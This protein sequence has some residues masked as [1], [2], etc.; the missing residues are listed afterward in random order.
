M[1]LLF[2]AFALH[3]PSSI[4]LGPCIASAI[5][6]RALFALFLPRDKAQEPN[7]PQLPPEA[8]GARA[9]P[10]PCI[11]PAASHS[12]RRCCA[13]PIRYSDLYKSAA[14]T[15][16]A[17]PIQPS[18]LPR[19]PCYLRPRHPLLSHEPTVTVTAARLPIAAARAWAA[20]QCCSRGL[21]SF[22]CRCV[23]SWP[24]PGRSLS[25]P[26]PILFR[27][28]C[29]LG[30][31]PARRSSFLLLSHL[32]PACPC[33]GAQ[34]QS[35]HGGAVGSFLTSV[36][37][38]AA[39]PPGRQITP[40][41]F[42]SF[43]VSGVVLPLAAA[44][45]AAGFFLAF[46]FLLSASSSSASPLPR[47]LCSANRFLFRWQPRTSESGAAVL[48]EFPPLPCSCQALPSQDSLQFCPARPSSRSIGG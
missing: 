2:L 14:H 13:T 32:L 7:I 17:T 31:P 29:L 43:P 22:R 19:S 1:L 42:F 30:S 21:G 48:G 25:P 24:P 46:A 12:S 34:Q 45:A 9:P 15:F 28:R 3:Q 37:S 26:H 39:V 41:L 23:R 38:S 36:P 18:I 47:R 35:N 27:C 40:R 16:P 20:S 44:A 8:C 11:S 10:P 4:F 5:L 33:L 6:H